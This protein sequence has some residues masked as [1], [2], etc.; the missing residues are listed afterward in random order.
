LVIAMK[1]MM[2]A[3]AQTITVPSLGVARKSSENE[4]QSA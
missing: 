1:T 3:P 2:S 4:R